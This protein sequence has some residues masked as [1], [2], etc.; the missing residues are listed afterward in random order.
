MR[1]VVFALVLLLVSASA[2]TGVH[3]S[4][5]C[6]RWLKEY[7]EALAHS[8]TVQRAKVA[9]HRLHHY[10]HRKLAAYHRPKPAPRPH[11]LPVRHHHRPMTKEEMLR[12]FELA[13]GDL[14]EDLPVTAT[15]PPTPPPVF[16]PEKSLDLGVEDLAGNDG[17]PLL[18]M[19]STPSYG[20]SQ[21]SYPGGPGGFGLPPGFPGGGYVPPK[22]PDT[23][24]SNPPPPPPI[25]TA[26]TP[27]PGSVVLVLTGISGGVAEMVRRRRARRA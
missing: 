11:A 5:D 21:S 12:R 25:Q 6:E 17:T 8:P 24:T 16:A 27:E 20:G 9:S 22:L 7:K 1:R 2:A 3:A 23:G 13:C 14:P 18:P 10:V 19:Q 15:L 26:P 4:T